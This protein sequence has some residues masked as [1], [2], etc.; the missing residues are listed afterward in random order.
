MDQRSGLDMMT[1]I[2]EVSAEMVWSL[3]SF[4]FPLPLPRLG[5]PSLEGGGTMNYIH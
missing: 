1:S 3:F 2:Q 4:P 5:N